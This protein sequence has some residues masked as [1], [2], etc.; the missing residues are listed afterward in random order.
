MVIKV[1]LG[2][3]SFTTSSKSKKLYT[4]ARDLLLATNDTFAKSFLTDLPSV[5]SFEERTVA[6]S[7]LAIMSALADLGP[8]VPDTAELVA[9]VVYS[10]PHQV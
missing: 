3:H 2:G 1:E 9:E 8:T 7:K 10:A 4:L 5:E 6:A